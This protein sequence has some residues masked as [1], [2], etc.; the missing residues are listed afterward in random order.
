[1]RQRCFPHKLL[2][3]CLFRLKV[4]AKCPKT[5][6]NA[7]DG[8]DFPCFKGRSKFAPSLRPP[9]HLFKKSLR[10]QCHYAV[11]IPHH[12]R[13]KKEK[14]CF[15]WVVDV[16]VRGWWGW[17]T[18]VQ[19]GSV[20]Q[21]GNLQFLVSFWLAVVGPRGKAQVSGFLRKLPASSICQESFYGL[22]FHG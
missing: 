12:S 22:S 17:K 16:W 21:I 20:F 4:L 1:M 5:I 8:K 19:D 2:R 7:K 3:L 6:G 10:R 9:P 11:L 15:G 18:V 13:V 14:G